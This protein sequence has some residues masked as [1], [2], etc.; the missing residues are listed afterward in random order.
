MPYCPL[1]SL[2]DDVL[3]FIGPHKRNEKKIVVPQQLQRVFLEQYHNS[4]HFTISEKW[5][6]QGVYKDAVKNCPA[7][8]ITSGTKRT[9]RPS[10]CP[11]PVS[12]ESIGVDIMDL[13]KTVDGNKHVIVFQD[14]LMASSLPYA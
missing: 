12:P 4:G 3:Y 9:A 7:Y 14:F 8:V 1:F 10:L 11:T 5:W 6:W 13:P 2:N